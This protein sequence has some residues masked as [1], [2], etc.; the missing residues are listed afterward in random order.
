MSLTRTKSV[1]QSLRDSE[2]PEHWGRGTGSGGS[3]R[4]L[5]TVMMII[6]LGQSRVA[7][8]MSRDGL[9]PR[10]LAHVHP[11]LRTPYRITIIVGAV[12]AILAVFIP[13]A[14]LAELVNIGTLFAFVLVSI[15]VVIL[16]RTQPDLPRTFRVPGMPVVPALAVLACVTLMLFLTV[17]TWLRFLVWMAV[18]FIVYFG[19]SRNRSRLGLEGPTLP[20]QEADVRAGAG[21]AARPPRG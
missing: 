13:L 15:G 21:G 20:P 14:E 4:G 5:T 9:L 6:M 16:R 19:Y 11:T 12:I 8:A 7:F 3:G 2:E 1:E 17:E 10:W 18:G